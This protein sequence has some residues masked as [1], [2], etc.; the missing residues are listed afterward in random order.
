[1][2]K[3]KRKLTNGTV[4]CHPELFRKRLKSLMSECGYSCERLGKNILSSNTIQG[5]LYGR[6]MPTAASLQII[7]S[8]FGVSADYLLGLS[9]VK[10][11]PP[12][13]IRKEGEWVCSWCGGKGDQHD[14]F[15]RSCG[16]EMNLNEFGDIKNEPGT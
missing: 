11:L 16:E 9:A 1:M 2:Y 12:Q 13:W 6:N 4:W 14:K 8:F 5:Y 10:Y 3:K 7:C 15:C